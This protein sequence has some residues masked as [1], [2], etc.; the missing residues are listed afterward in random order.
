MLMSFVF[1]FSACS[2]DNGAPEN[3]ENNEIS[4]G[5]GEQKLT[6]FLPEPK[7]DGN[8]SVEKALVNRRSHRNFQD[9]A[10]SEEQLSQILWAAYGVTSPNPDDPGQRGGLR[11]AP[12]AG[13]L[14]PLEV[15]AIVGSVEGISPGVYRYISGGHIIERVVE[16]D[17]RNDIREAALGQ[18]MVSQAPVSLFYSAVFERTTGRYG[19]NGEKY[20]YIEAG[21][22]AQNV[23]LQAEALGL[24][25]CAIGALTGG[26][27][28]EILKLPENEVPLY[29]LPVGYY[30][31]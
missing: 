26:R 28:S 30:D 9:K 23:Y 7:S 12:S 5:T 29:L 10:I 16:G 20:V 3:Q 18:S 25:T 27:V 19:D 22:S 13:A 8:T 15:Y 24:G 21:H 2:S 31:G 11:T 17:V 1:A 4:T 6:Y 14:Y